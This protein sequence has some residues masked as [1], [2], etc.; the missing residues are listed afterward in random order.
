MIYPRAGLPNNLQSLEYI[1]IG[2]I[3]NIARFNQYNY[4]THLDGEQQYLRKSS[5]EIR[6]KWHRR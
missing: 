2:R 5:S 1:Q 4:V 6:V 3:E